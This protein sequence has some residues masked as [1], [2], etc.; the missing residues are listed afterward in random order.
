MGCVR[1][2]AT[3]REGGR[4]HHYVSGGSPTPR[5]EA[6]RPLYRSRIRT[7]ALAH[8]W[9]GVRDRSTEVAGDET[10]LQAHLNP[11]ASDLSTEVTM[12]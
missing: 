4:L 1:Q 10:W 6:T 3:V 7:W 8:F 5:V 9:P 2:C 11:D 12:L